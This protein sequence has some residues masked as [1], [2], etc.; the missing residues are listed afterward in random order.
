MVETS[1]RQLNQIIEKEK[2]PLE[3]ED[4]N[5]SSIPL[6]EIVE[7]SYRLEAS[8]YNIE[9][10]HARELLLNGKYPVISL[11]GEE[12]LIEK[13]YYPGR[14]KRI[15]T[16]KESGIPFYLPSQM[17]DI[18]PI[19]DKFISPLTNCSIKEL[20][21][22][23]G[24]LLL[25]RSGTIGNV[26]IV[27]KTLSGKVFSD[28][29]IRTKFKGEADLGYVYAYLKTDTGRIIL[30]TNSYGSVI[31]HIEPEHFKEMIIP[32]APYLIK[33]R[34]H[35]K[36]M[37]SFALRDESN[38][39]IDK[40]TKMLISELKLP[41]IDELKLNMDILD[42]EVMA[43]SVKLSELNQRLESSYHNPLAIKVENL[44]QD[45]VKTYK[46]GDNKISKEIILPGRFKRVYVDEG[47]GK[48]FIG[49][50]QLFELDP[51]DKKYLS[52]TH[53][54]KRIKDELTL[55][56]NMILVTCSGTIGKVMIVPQ[57]WESW[58]VNQHVLRVVP[59]SKSIAGYIYA[60]LNSEY[61]KILIKKQ[62]YGSVVDEINDNHI[63][64]VLI[65]ML[66]NHSTI[67]SINS[68]ILKANGKRYQAY[69]LEQQAINIMNK[70]VIG[71]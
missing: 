39:L 11:D 67:E 66:S 42:K 8:V 26:T 48:V 38:V 36:I 58:T 44:L 32:D 61:G 12:G 70:E 17:T 4:I 28:D 54:S 37:E 57:H 56:E 9:A 65:P 29:I 15:Y 7:K 33:K 60:W 46:V 31:T 52:I 53:H 49:G 14:F 21:M 50:K 23:E 59:A 55:H 35:D 27:T 51:S 2:L 30:K 25:S 19:A 10:K 69:H 43:Y 71:L 22:K 41:S 34:I 1:V 68:L 6:S 40:A 20:S 5:W 62:I 24:T 16:D 13:S 63:A 47:Y 3:K 45:N 18:Q 64:D